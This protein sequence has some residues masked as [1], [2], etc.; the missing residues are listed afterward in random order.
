MGPSP[1]SLVTVDAAAVRHNVRLLRQRLRPG[2]RFLAAVKAD[3]YGHG[4]LEC[5]AAALEAGADGVAVA[6]AEEAVALRDAG[7]ERSILVMG[8]LY[9]PDQCAEMTRRA[10]EFAVVSEEMTPMLLAL[11]GSGVKT[12]FHLKIDTGMNRQGLFPEQVPAFL[13]AIRGNDELELA[14]VMTHFAAADDPASLDLQLERFLPCVRLVRADWPHSKAHAANSAATLYSPRA[15]LDMVRCGIAVY[16]LSPGQGDATAEGLRPALSWTSQVAL[17]K[18]VSAGEG[19]GYGHTFRPRSDTDVALVPVGYADGV[20][21]LLSNRGQ[22]LIG[23][24]RYPMVG[25]VSMDSFGVDVGTEGLVRPG[26]K[27]TLIGRDGESRLSAEEVA[28][29]AETINYEVTCNISIS[30]AERV[31]VDE[32]DL[33]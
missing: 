33:A 18:R 6:T 14:G 17:V 19:V 27:V 31:F 23:G 8:P 21:R 11:A 26:A 22:V 7:F 16:G 2:V 5:A 25:R 3:G 24:R 12:R 20:F 9:G 10:V 29:W 30:R 13:E 15:H 32:G 28:A 4:G 1:R